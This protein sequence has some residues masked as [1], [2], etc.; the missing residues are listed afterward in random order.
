MT[1]KLVKIGDE[2]AIEFTEEMMKALNINDDTVLE[3]KVKDNN[4]LITP[5]RE[6]KPDAKNKNL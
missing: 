4:I 2:L 5:V 3:I 6:K 1:T